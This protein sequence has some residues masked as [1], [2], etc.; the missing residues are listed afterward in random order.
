MRLFC[1]EKESTNKKKKKKERNTLDTQ[2]YRVKLGDAGDDFINR[3]FIYKFNFV[4]T[5]IH[6]HSYK[7][8]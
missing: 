5:N 6:T 8:S 4:Y 7:N 1:R 3:L 2:K